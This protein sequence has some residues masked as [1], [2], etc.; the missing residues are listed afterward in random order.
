MGEW[1]NSRTGS[2]L[3]ANG[4]LSAIAGH[5]FW[6][7][8]FDFDQTAGLYL[9]RG[10][11][12]HSCRFQYYTLDFRLNQLVDRGVELKAHGQVAEFLGVRVSVS[13]S[14]LV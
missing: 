5:H 9:V 13:F 3:R 7:G 8:H 1:G 6:P 14:K 12:T 4:Q 10:H 11:S 2:L